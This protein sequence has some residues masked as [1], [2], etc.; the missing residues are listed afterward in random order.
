MN[1][2]TYLRYEILRNIRIWQF[3]VF[4]LAFPLVLYFTVAGANRH[5]IFNG[6][7]F[8]LYF[9]TAMATVG[10]MIAVVSRGAVI[11]AERAIGWTREIRITPLRTAVYLGAKILCGYL[12]ALLTIAVI[13]AAG[14]ALGVRLSASAWVTVVGLLLIGLVPFAMLSI[15]LGHVLNSDSLT[16]AVGGITTLFALLG[17]AYGFQIA[18]SGAM[19][20]VIKA[21]PSYWLV[22]AGRTA[23]AGGGWPLEGWIVITVWSVVLARLA[24]LAYRRDTRRT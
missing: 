4:S 24:M 2:L 1:T 14:I 18:R 7:E 16:P 8:P 19:F 9:M 15:F 11:A 10:T 3:L 23:L 21:L 20:E 12:M 22:Q 6:V 13:S 17:G 5:A